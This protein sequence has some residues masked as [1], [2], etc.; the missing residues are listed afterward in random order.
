MYNIVVVVAVIIIAIIIFVLVVFI[1]V[2]VELVDVYFFVDLF[3]C[4]FVC[5]RVS[6]T[7][8]VY[9]WLFAGFFYLI[10]FCVKYIEEKFRT[11]RTTDTI[12]RHK[13]CANIG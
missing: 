8:F 2:L 11:T 6:Y 5:L 13:T 9:C 7:A 12:F 3:V 4:L 10:C 1:V